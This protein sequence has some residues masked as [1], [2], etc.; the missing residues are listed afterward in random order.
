MNKLSTP[1]QTSIISFFDVKE[2]IAARETCTLWRDKTDK[3]AVVLAK[4][5]FTNLFTPILLDLN[6]PSVALRMLSFPR[7]KEIHEREAIR[8]KIF[9]LPSFQ[10]AILMGDKVQNFI[11]RHDCVGARNEPVEAITIFEENAQLFRFRF[12]RNLYDPHR[13][14]FIKDSMASILA[15][16]QSAVTINAST[17]NQ[18]CRCQIL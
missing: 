9:E 15:L 18:Q 5:I 8:K 2:L 4:S 12:I 10:V 6:H 13:P 16:L 11:L 3:R 14:C 17:K 1:L 7:V